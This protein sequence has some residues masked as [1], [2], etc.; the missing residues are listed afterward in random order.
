VEPKTPAAKEM[1]KNETPAQVDTPPKRT[2][3]SIGGSVSKETPAVKPSEPTK[4]EPAKNAEP[5]NA[6]L[7]NTEPPKKTESPKVEPAKNVDPPK[8]TEPPKNTLP[9]NEP[10]KATTKENPPKVTPAKVEPPKVEPPK[11]EPPKETP[12]DLARKKVSE[13]R[14]LV[15]QRMYDAAIVIANEALALDS[16]LKSAVEVKA[17]ALAGRASDY[18]AVSKW[19]E[20]I[21]DYTAAIE[22]AATATY[23]VQRGAAHMERNASNDPK[24]ALDDF[25]EALVL[26][27]RCT[28][29]FA[30]RGAALLSQ[31]QFQGA[32]NDLS[33]AIEINAET[34]G[35]AYKAG[36]VH[37]LRALAER[38][39]GKNDLATLDDQ[40]AALLDR[41][42]QTPSDK[43][44][45]DKLGEL[46]GK[47]AE[48]RGK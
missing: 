10:P 44:L 15:R 19:N 35:A 21:A 8:V 23:Y 11:V 18:A 31:G 28:D 41:L 38:S 9:K 48:L 34:P 42:D 29:A 5:K 3:A 1:P 40:I 12:T 6:D 33:K 17:D 20:T 25:G 24:A 46:Q 27:P 16:K 26:D 7:K 43:S 39:A 37:N 22:I 45:Q 2:A 36:P 13:A 4:T 30:L 14:T 47:Y 32:I